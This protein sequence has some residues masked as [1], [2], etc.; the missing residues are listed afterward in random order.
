MKIF[1]FFFKAR[2]RVTLLFDVFLAPLF[3]FVLR[4]LRVSQVFTPRMSRTSMRYKKQTCELSQI[5]MLTSTKAEEMVNKCEVC[6]YLNVF[7]LSRK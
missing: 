5:T 4:H 3:S 7:V 1:S 2:G 6:Y